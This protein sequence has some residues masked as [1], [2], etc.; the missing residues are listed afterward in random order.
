MFN[1]IGLYHFRWRKKK[2]DSYLIPA[3]FFRN[4]RPKERIDAVLHPPEK[5]QEQSEAKPQEPVVSTPVSPVASTTTTAAPKPKEEPQP[6]IDIAR[7]N[8]QKVSALS[9]KSIQKKQDLKKQLELNKPSKEELPT[10]D[11]TQEQV[12]SAWKAYTKKMEGE[13]RYNLVSH[14]SMAVPKKQEDALVL[15]FPNSTIKVELESAQYDLLKF[16]RDQLNNY[17]VHL[18][19]S[20]NETIQK[21]YA[22]TPKEKFDKLNELNPL[23]ETLRKEFDLDV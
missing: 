15:E 8:A 23:M 2:S 20:V 7:K 6:K 16:L 13:G 11:F 1:A 4:K 12:D 14:M 18:E 19:I 10:Q 5:T 3:S 22:Y 21:R 17:N 9:I